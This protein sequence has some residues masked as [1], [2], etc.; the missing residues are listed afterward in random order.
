MLLYDG[1]DPFNPALWVKRFAKYT[2]YEKILRAGGTPR[3]LPLR[4]ESR[5]SRS[6]AR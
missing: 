6:D 5:P 3:G 1:H 2:H 4:L